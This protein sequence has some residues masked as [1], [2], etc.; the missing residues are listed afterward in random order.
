MKRTSGIINP[1]LSRV[2]AECG[3]T[4]AL[5]VADA[6]LPIPLGVERIDLAYRAGSP[7]FL[8]I[9]D[10]VL[11]EFIVERAVISGEMETESPGMLAAVKE[12]LDQFGVSVEAVPHGEFKA[13]TRDARAI[14]RTGEYTPYSNVML[15]SGAPF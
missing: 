7:A 8:D 3:H 6:G 14:V 10:S 9:L 1:Q 11:A 13:L 15:F 4:D 5:V 12:R 2:I